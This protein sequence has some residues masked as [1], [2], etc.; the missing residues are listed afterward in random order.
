MNYSEINQAILEGRDINP[1]KVKKNGEFYRYLLNNRIAYYYAKELSKTPND[2]EQALIR[3][4]D[5][6]NEKYLRTLRHLVSLC[7]R[8]GFE[9]LL[10]KT[11]KVVPE[12]NDGDIDI[13]VKR[14]DF[15]KM[16]EAYKDEGFYAVEDE[17]GK[18]KC[19]KEGYSVVEPHISVSWRGGE[20]V[21]EKEIWDLAPVPVAINGMEIRLAPNNIELL[22]LF[23]KVLYEPAYLDLYSMI[24]ISH[25]LQDTPA[26]SALE[27][28]PE[29]KQIHRYI[30]NL[31]WNRNI[32]APVFLPASLYL[33]LWSGL[34]KHVGL[35]TFSLHIVY[36][37]YWK[38]RYLFMNIL[39]FTHHG[40]NP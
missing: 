28:H 30:E 31:V 26:K 10:Y 2:S 7:K 33:S 29:L 18:G 16:L 38:Y 14:E 35:K 20:A 21:N 17:P 15:L 5:A 11:W 23:A 12:V 40:R 32:K 3:E 19:E 37:F 13:I 8:N 39:P 27:R 6:I 4:S 25:F 34:L 36:F 22:A 24:A 1:A 9:F